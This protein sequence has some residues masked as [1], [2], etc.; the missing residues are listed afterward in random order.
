MKEKMNLFL[1][2]VLLC[3]LSLGAIAEETVLTIQAMKRANA[4]S[5]DTILQ[6]DLDMILEAG[7]S[8][9]NQLDR[10]PWQFVAITDTSVLDNISNEAET[11]FTDVEEESISEE[12]IEKA[13]EIAGGFSD[14]PS[15]TEAPAAIVIYAD[16][17]SASPNA[18]FDCGAAAQNMM[19]AANAMGYGSAVITSPLVALN[20]ENHDSW[21]LQFGVDPEMK[22]VAVV[23]IGTV[24]E[25]S[26]LEY[27][28]DDLMIEKVSYVQ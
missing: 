27:S 13:A 26:S 5:E 14:E 17:A 20:G 19:H 4:F 2:I 16:N 7:V 28:I 9:V 10:Q 18:N 6:E 15:A 23:L 12:I 21:C 22:A 11:A 25:V 24:T 3:C 8:T 1:V